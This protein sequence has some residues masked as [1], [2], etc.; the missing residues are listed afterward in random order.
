[1]IK[2]AEIFLSRS[3]SPYE[4]LATE[5]YITSHLTKREVVLFLWRNRDTIVI[6]RNQNCWRECRV[7][8][9]LESGGR[10][11]R[12]LS[13]GGAVYH[14]EGNLNFSFIYPEGEFSTE[15][16]LD[17]IARACRAHGIEAEIS[18]RNDILT[19]GA[20]FSG[21]AFYSLTGE[22]GVKGVCH[23]G[24]I[25]ISADTGRLAEFLNV[26]KEKLESKGVKSVRSRVVNLG[27]IA[28]GLT[29]EGFT[30]SLAS[31]FDEK[32]GVAAESCEL[33]GEALDEIKKDAEQ[34]ASDEWIFGRK[35][36]F[37][38]S[39][40]ARFPWG[41]IR[42]D[43]KVSAGVVSECGV[44]S[45]SMDPSISATLEAAL[46]GLPF[47]AKELE[48]VIKLEDDRVKGDIV[49]LLYENI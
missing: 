49:G 41:E 16:G 12:R 19:K 28:E 25:L 29:A 14:D 44:Y 31:A 5:K 9:F 8:E 2:K 33:T 40:G 11:A 3:F 6:G 20:K 21:N 34:L 7:S 4:N 35:I 24:C 17:V 30:E 18:G 22:N 26:S 42:L 48:N 43:F 13:G 15:E 23:H 32:M 45:D 46:T 37:T 1:M 39:F 47:S 10:I 27:S 36:D 38:D